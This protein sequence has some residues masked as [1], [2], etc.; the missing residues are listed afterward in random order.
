MGVLFSSM[1]ELGSVKTSMALVLTVTKI[2]SVSENLHVCVP[3]L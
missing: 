1:V 3:A 2:Q